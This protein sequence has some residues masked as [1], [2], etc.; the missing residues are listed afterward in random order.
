LTCVY[1][2]VCV[3]ATLCRLVDNEELM[4]NNNH[5]DICLLPMIHGMFQLHSRV[6][7]HMF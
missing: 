2:G 7:S 6:F 5:T 3:L 4:R 1:K